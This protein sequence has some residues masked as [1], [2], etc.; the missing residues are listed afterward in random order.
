MLGA[1]RLSI[2]SSIW[3]KMKVTAVDRHHIARNHSLPIGWM[4][5]VQI[6]TVLITPFAYCREDM[7]KIAA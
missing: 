1:A 7:F 3:K 4:Q 2:E 6:G 5:V